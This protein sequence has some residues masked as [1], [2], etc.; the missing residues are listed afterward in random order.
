MPGHE[1]Q[2]TAESL[3]KLSAWRNTVLHKAPRNR[4]G[5]VV[6]RVFFPCPQSDTSVTFADFRDKKYQ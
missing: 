4:L 6:A 5:Y 1:V 2:S 3:E